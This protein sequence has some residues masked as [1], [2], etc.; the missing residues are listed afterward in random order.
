MRPTVLLLLLTALTF[1]PVT[2]AQAQDDR[3]EI[4]RDCADDDILQGSYPASKM[5]DALNNMPAELEEYSK[6]RDILSREI[7]Q[8]TA[9]TKPAG[10]GEHASPAAGAGGTTGGSG[11]GSTPSSPV[12][13]ATPQ[14]T[15]KDVGVQMGPSTPQDWRAIDGAI[16]KGGDAVPI[17]GR[18]ISPAA[19]VGRNGMPASVIVVLALLA[20]AGL[21]VSVPSVRRRVPTRS[22]P[23]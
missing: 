13:T 12:A 11:G 23:A 2:A 3:V 7:G 19:A 20:A 1:V 8:R 9:A 21:A 18:P 14:R 16:E 22:S 17:N 15:G 10:D 4:L 5:R 6:C